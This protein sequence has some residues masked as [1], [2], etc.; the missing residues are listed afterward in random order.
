MV[1]VGCRAETRKGDKQ[2]LRIVLL[3]NDWLEKSLTGNTILGQQMFDTS[4]DVKMFVRRQ[5]ALDNSRT[6]III[7]SPERWIHYSF[8]DPSLVNDN[9]T[10][11]MAMCPPGP[12]AFLMVIPISPHRGREWTVEGPLELLNDTVWRNTIV[13]FTRCERLRGSS[14][15][16]YTERHRFL[17]AVLER[18]GQRYHLLDTSI[19]GDDDDAQV[20]ELLEKIDATVAG[21]IKAGAVGWLTTNEEVSRITGRERKELEERAILRRINMQKSRKT[22]R[23]LMGESPPISMLRVL[24]VGP[25][26]VGRS[27]AGNTILGKEVFPAGLQTSQCTEGRGDIHKRQVT[28]VEAPGWHGRYCSEDT[29]REVQ[30]QMC[31][32][33]SLCAPIPNSVLV[34]VRSDETFTETD[35]LRAEEHLSLLGVWVW[36]RAIVLFTWGDKLG[37]T[38]IEEHIE[39]WPALKWL[40]DK[41]G[42]RYHVFDNSNKVGDIQVKELLAKIEETEVENDTG[43]LLRSFIKLQE[44]NQKL[45]QSSKNKARQ[46]KKARSDIDLLTQTAK[47]KE[48]IVEDM[49]KSAKEKDEQIE[50]LKAARESEERKDR[51]YEEEIGRGLVEA[52]RENNQLKQVILG[53]KEMI[54]SLCERCAVKDDVIKATKQSSEVEK[55]VLEERVKE[56]EQETAAFKEKCAK[57]DKAHDQMMMNQKREAKELEE[58]IKQLKRE[59]ED[60]KKALKATIEGVQRHY[61]KKEIDRR[62][63]TKTVDFN[64][65]NQLRK[66][67]TDVKSLEELA[68]Q[69]KWAFAVHLSHHKEEEAKPKT[70]KNRLAVLDD[71]I[72]LHEKKETANQVWQLKAD[73]TP[74]WLRAGGAALGAAFGALV[75]SSRVTAGMSTRSAVGAAAGALLGSLLVQGARLQQGEMESDINSESLP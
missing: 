63:E 40:V 31:H 45:D 74:S 22:L 1:S 20:A 19:W 48:R 66:T 67:M 64:K 16:G 11:C 62:N 33:V 73:W 52:K 47:E 30:Q 43:H 34:V 58:T 6:V 17:K 75:S 5:G 37:V 68:R 59:N 18:C 36:T 29:P 8:R 39:S 42:N 71:D 2:E 70:E 69:Q 15:E 61:K 46:L 27:S 26:Q 25:K 60:T 72:M 21:N 24:I 4:R 44:T 3:G 54:T 55:E 32:S 28:V 12:H 9:M 56:Q 53:K 7:N 13:I 51:D 65:S 35:R 49:I 38:P 50:A 10:A 14:I 23:S 41:C 57:K